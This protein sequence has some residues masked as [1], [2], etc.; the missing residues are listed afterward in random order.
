M[1]KTAKMRDELVEAGEDAA[2]VLEFVEK[3]LDEMPFT[4]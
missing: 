1:D 4:I 2:K 3:A